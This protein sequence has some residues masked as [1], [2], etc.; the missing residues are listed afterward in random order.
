MASKSPFLMKSFGFSNAF[1]PSLLFNIISSDIQQG[2]AR[3][4]KSYDSGAC[5]LLGEGFEASDLEDDKLHDDI[6]LIF[7]VIFL[8]LKPQT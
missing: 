1:R 6:G 2:L 3:V 5:R 7:H 8:Q 4:V